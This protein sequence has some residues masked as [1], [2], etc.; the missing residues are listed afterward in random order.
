MHHA[1]FVRHILLACVLLAAGC[2]F[3]TDATQAN[4]QSVEP[5]ATPFQPVIGAY[6]PGGVSLEQGE[7]AGA[8]TANWYLSPDLPA[9]YAD[10]LV[11]P[12]G[13]QIVTD[14]SQAHLIISVNQG[15]SLSHWMYA[16]VAPFPTLTDE[17]A[18]EDLKADWLGQ[19]K[20]PF[21]GT[22]LMLT[23]QTKA[24]FTALWG[25]PA[26]GAVQVEDA[27][28][29]LDAAWAVKP[30]WALVP[31]GDLEAKWKVLTV[32]GQSPIHKDFDEQTYA[33]SVPIGLGGDPTLVAEALQRFGNDSEAPLAPA[34][35]RD[36][37][38]LTTVV[39][40]GVTAL[41]RA[42]AYTMNQKGITYPA[43]DI[44]DLL[45]SADITHISNEV[46]FSPDCPL[47]DPV[48]RNL[49][50]CSDP[51]YIQ[52]LDDVGADVIDLTGD[53]F[54]DWTEQ[55]MLYTLDLYKQHGMQYYGGGTNIEEGQRPLLLD[56]HGNKI[57]F[58]GCNAKGGGY[59]TAS[60]TYPGAVKCD[61]DLIESQIH[62]LV[63]QGYTVIFTFQHNEVYT[64]VPAESLVRDFTA[65]SAAGASIVSGSQAHVPH[66]MELPGDG[67]IITYGLGNLFFDQRGVVDYGDQAMI[68][69]HVIYDNKY[70]STEIFTIQFVD[71]AKPRFMTQDERDALLTLVFDASRWDYPSK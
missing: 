54:N 6:S 31:F 39:L 29:L 5:S 65:V 15:E 67:R 3:P 59:A 2:N 71:Y 8:A 51:D 25:A 69:R 11:L 63:S 23:N 12:D 17:V 60:E 7:V 19:G 49:V 1:R 24:V 62:D 37:S 48:Q 58:L 64:F 61:L 21:A 70:I 22:P 30:A 53:H 9:G 40:T 33:L 32:D 41:V 56:D 36:A 10:Q 44:R 35:N 45:R 42:T 13:A 47:P 27:G 4:Q 52:L 38:K 43:E 68:A 34:S 16:L 18:F 66:G 14:E 28:K 20:G 50:F 55:A 57:A 46:A 26:A